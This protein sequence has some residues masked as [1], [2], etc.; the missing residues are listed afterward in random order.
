MCSICANISKV[1]PSN[2][3]ISWRYG[4]LYA[5]SWYGSVDEFY[6]TRDDKFLPCVKKP[7]IFVF[8][9]R[10]HLIM[11]KEIGL[12]PEN[13]ENVEYTFQVEIK[14]ISGVDAQLVSV[15]PAPTVFRYLKPPEQYYLDQIQQVRTFIS[16]DEYLARV[17]SSVKELLDKRGIL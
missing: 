17:E 3:N 10:T 2:L 12:G 11:E 9:S 5:Y 8:N 16:S 7:V 15:G 6:S 1:V 14:G 13:P 4:S